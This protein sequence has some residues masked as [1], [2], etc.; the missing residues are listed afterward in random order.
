MLKKITINCLLISIALSI[1]AC[2]P[3]RKDIRN[4]DK[5]YAGGLINTADYHNSR[6]RLQLAEEQWRAT[7]AANLNQLSQNLNQIQQN[8]NNASAVEAYNRRTNVLA[9]PTEVNVRHT[10]YINHNVNIYSY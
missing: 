9:Q 4:L 5:A 8:M 10:G 6:S 1:G 7:V 2:S 3:Y